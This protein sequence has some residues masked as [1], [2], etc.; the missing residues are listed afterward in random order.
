MVWVR[1]STVA[2]YMYQIDIIMC[3]RLFCL[4]GNQYL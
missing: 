1:N 4:S 2:D 3:P